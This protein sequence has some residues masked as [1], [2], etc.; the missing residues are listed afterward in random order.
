M[1]Y[2]HAV[3]GQQKNPKVMHDEWACSWRTTEKSAKIK[4]SMS[5]CGKTTLFFNTCGVLNE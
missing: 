5:Y 1:T 4:K 3:G 2:G